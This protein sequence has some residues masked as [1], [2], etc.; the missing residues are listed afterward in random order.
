[1]GHDLGHGVRRFLEHGLAQNQPRVALL[2]HQQGLAPVAKEHQVGFP[3][4]GNAA[5][6]SL[7]G[8]LGQGAA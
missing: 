7:F 4:A 2:E 5:I 1:M 8:T 3:M 6:L